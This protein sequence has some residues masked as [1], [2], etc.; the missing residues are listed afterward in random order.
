MEKNTQQFYRNKFNIYY[1]PIHSFFVG[2]QYSFVLDGLWKCVSNVYLKP[3]I[4]IIKLKNK[5]LN[6]LKNF[7]SHTLSVITTHN[8]NVHK[9][10]NLKKKVKISEI[11]RKFKNT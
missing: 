6:G 10:K 9:F 1:N 2:Q 4:M 5:G 7:G 3:I 8:F 11:F